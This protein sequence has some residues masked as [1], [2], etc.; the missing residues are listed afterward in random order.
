MSETTQVH[1]DGPD[2]DERNGERET[3]DIEAVLTSLSK[4]RRRRLLDVLDD[5]G[6]GTFAEVVARVSEEI[7][8]EDY[9]RQERKRVYVSLYQNHVPVLAENG[10]VVFEGTG[11]D[12][13]LYPG[14]AFP[15]TKDA[16]ED[17]GVASNG[18]ERR[19]ARGSGPSGISYSPTLC[20]RRRS[21]LLHRRIRP[22]PRR[23]P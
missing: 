22:V 20:P 19:T 1:S 14:P 4:E 10:V 23:N 11:D 6:G 9:D 18:V 16:L 13:R 8:G 5:G 7:Y 15:E 17:S 2:P 21:R 3:T 12:D